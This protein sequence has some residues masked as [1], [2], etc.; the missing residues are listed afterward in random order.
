MRTWIRTLARVVLLT[1]TLAW[2]ASP[3]AAQRIAGDY[4]V[5]VTGWSHMLDRDP[6]RIR[7]Q[8]M[9]TLRI[10]QSGDLIKLEFGTFASAMAATLFEG[11]V[12]GEA[13]VATWTNT[14]EAVVAITGSVEG[15]VLVGELLYTRYGEGRVPGWVDVR[16]RAQPESRTTQATRPGPGRRVLTRPPRTIPLRPPAASQPAADD[17]EG[18]FPLE[19]F[20]ITEPEVPT[21]AQR[22]TFSAR[23]TPRGPHTVVRT[24][25]WMNGNLQVS[26]DG[27]VAEFTAGPF[28]P[29]V[30]TYDVVA[31]SAD[32]VRSEPRSATVDVRP[33]GSTV[34]RGQITGSVSDVVEIQLLTV[35]ERVV[36]RTGLTGSGTYRFTSIPS[37]TYVLYVQMAG[38]KQ[39]AVRP[40]A[41]VRLEV[42]GR[43]EYRRDFQ[44]R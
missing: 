36:A 7:I 27:S 39:D 29:G 2:A 42:D 3:A 32:G 25:I 41:T 26:A 30:L 4:E 44:I 37:G 8:D 17:S 24:E 40:S 18:S 22:I 19:V 10:E 43:D 21:S 1:V 23:A 11:R 34:I 20:S 5:E 13:F 6:S 12:G 16:F 38:G 33:A 9:T 31:I 15:D 28:E 14:P 35:D